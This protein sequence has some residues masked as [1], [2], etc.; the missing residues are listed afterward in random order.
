VEGG[1]LEEFA[2]GKRGEQSQDCT[3]IVDKGGE[4][5]IG[6]AVGVRRIGTLVGVDAIVA[7]L[8]GEL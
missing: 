1:G 2:D 7:G 8:L 6:R 5:A 3:Q 4:E